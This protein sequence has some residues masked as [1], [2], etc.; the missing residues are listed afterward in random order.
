MNYYAEKNLLEEAIS[1]NGVG[2][3]LSDNNMLD[4]TKL[5]VMND[6][7]KD[8]F[9]QGAASR[10]NGRTKITYFVSGYSPLSE[11]VERM[12][13]DAFVSV[14]ASIFSAINDIVDNGFFK[15]LDIDASISKIFVDT[16]NLSV[17]MVC[18]PINYKYAAD[19]DGGSVMHTLR[20]EL[21]EIM[22]KRPRLRDSADIASLRSIVANGNNISAK[23][24]YREICRMGTTTHSQQSR[25]QTHM[26]P[27][28]TCV[29]YNIP[30]FRII[31]TPFVIGRSHEKADGCVGADKMAV[32]RCH[33]EIISDARGYC[34]VDKKSLHGTRLN[35]RQLQP[36]QPY[37]LKNGDMLAIANLLFKVSM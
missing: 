4:Q 33:C 8:C 25:A 22:E 26:I 15:L 32:S 30:D 37:P 19:S 27:E 17:H 2:Y 36:D 16:S 11:Q 5:K 35:G 34:V 29:N 23:D 12:T 14:T 31:R 18:L 13:P 1:L 20:H 24:I 10:Y 28:L 9:V 6:P 7:N 21:L 3:L